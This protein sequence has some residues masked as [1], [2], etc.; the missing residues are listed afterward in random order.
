MKLYLTL[1]YVIPETFPICFP[2]QREK[3][4][5]RI[6]SDKVRSALSSSECRHTAESSG[7]A[8]SSEGG[9]EP[10]QKSIH[11]L[12]HFP[13]HQPKPPAPGDSETR[14]CANIIQPSDSVV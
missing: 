2:F 10:S 1:R 8:V 7:A 9:K 12:R 4:L 3:S 6:G 5:I 11:A 14:N 13:S